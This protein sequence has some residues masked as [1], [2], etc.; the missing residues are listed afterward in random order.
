MGCHICRPSAKLHFEDA[1]DS[2]RLIEN[3]VYELREDSPNC[4]LT[5]ETF[6]KI[7]IAISKPHSIHATAY[8]AL[9]KHSKQ[10]FVANDLSKFRP[11]CGK[12]KDR[13]LQH[14][15]TSFNSMLYLAVDGAISSTAAYLTISK[16]I[17]LSWAMALPAP[18]TLL[19]DKSH[20][21]RRLTATGLQIGRFIDRIVETFRILAASMTNTEIFFVKRWLIALGE[22]IK[23]SHEFWLEKYKTE[24]PQNHMAWHVFGTHHLTRCCKCSSICTNKVFH[25]YVG[26]TAIAMF[27]DDDALL[28]YALRGQ[29]SSTGGMIINN[30]YS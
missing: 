26:M 19:A 23:S 7:R 14:A 12:D 3:V 29:D 11:Y 24:G 1:D 2:T 10:I 13:F 8:K 4:F 30:I 16:Q 20:P 22:T 28:Q 9:K 17:L 6:A 15:K 21:S 18:G 5:P 25:I 27:T